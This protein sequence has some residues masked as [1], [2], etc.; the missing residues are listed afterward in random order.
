MRAPLRNTTLVVFEVLNPFA[1]HRV[2]ASLFRRF[3][4]KTF[5]SGTRCA[6]FCACV[7]LALFRSKLP[8]LLLSLRL[9]ISASL[10][11]SLPYRYHARCH[12]SVYASCSSLPV[13]LSPIPSHV[14]R[15]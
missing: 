4:S 11:F 15:R 7:A 14:A 12:A 6:F 5:T 13:A 10:S 3:N 1:R 2:Y 9:S 8:S